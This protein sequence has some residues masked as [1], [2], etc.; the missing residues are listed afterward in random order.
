MTL[1]RTLLPWSLLKTGRA[2][3]AGRLVLLLLLLLLSSAGVAQAQKTKAMTVS[4]TVWMPP[5]KS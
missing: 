3:Y 2:D 5:A 1:I 4:G